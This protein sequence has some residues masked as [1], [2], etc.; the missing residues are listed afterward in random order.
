MIMVLGRGY[1]YSGEGIEKHT[2]SE[3]GNKGKEKEM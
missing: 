1:M 2:R 3:D